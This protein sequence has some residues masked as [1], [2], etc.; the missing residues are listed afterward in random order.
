LKLEKIYSRENQFG[1]LRSNFVDY[2]L[3]S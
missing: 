1:R 3:N 2:S